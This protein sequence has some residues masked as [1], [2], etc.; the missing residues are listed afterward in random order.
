MKSGKISLQKKGEKKQNQLKLLRY[1][2][3][4]SRTARVPVCM[5]EG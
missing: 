4:K 2:K 1:K 3:S 5:K